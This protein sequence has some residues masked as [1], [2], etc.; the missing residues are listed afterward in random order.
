MSRPDD[1]T[2]PPGRRTPPERPS[3]KQPPL[4]FVT[5]TP[6]ARP[7]A[8]A[9]SPPLNA[10]ELMDKADN[11]ELALRRPGW[12]TT[13]PGYEPANNAYVNRKSKKYASWAAAVAIG[14]QIFTQTVPMLV[15][16]YEKHLDRQAQRE[17]SKG[18]P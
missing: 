9:S 12:D 17:L 5:P 18:H 7:S 6:K 3:V 10:A 14:F 4:E 16:L 1:D 8:P 2:A 11:A 13:S 15:E